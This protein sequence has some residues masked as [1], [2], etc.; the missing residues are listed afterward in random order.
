VAKKKV[1]LQK[2]QYSNIKIITIGSHIQ[3]CKYLSFNNRKNIGQ[4]QG[5]FH[6][7]V[8]SAQKKYHNNLDL[9]FVHDI[10]I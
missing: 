5:R 9:T 4:N 10:E 7:I 2:A 6:K 8:I 1:W 3:K